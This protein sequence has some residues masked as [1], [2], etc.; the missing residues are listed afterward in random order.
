MDLEFSAVFEVLSA[1]GLLFRDLGLLEL[2]I[3]VLLD[4]VN[5]KCRF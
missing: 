3:S 4:L 1:L 5:W 2:I